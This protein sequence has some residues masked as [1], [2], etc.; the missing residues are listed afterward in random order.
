M[1]KYVDYNKIIVKHCLKYY[2]ICWLD[3]NEIANNKII[4][5]D[6]VIRWYKNERELVINSKYPQVVKYTKDNEINVNNKSNE[7]I[8]RWIFIL[9]EIRR[10]SEKINQMI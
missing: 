1:K 7:Y 10:Q 5:R 9:K 2:W 3:R 4:Q 6:R 8:K